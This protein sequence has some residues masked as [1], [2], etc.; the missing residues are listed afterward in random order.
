[1]SY[2]IDDEYLFSG[3]TL[4]SVAIGRLDLPTSDTLDMVKSL[5]L[6][7]D[8]PFNYMYTG[9]GRNSTKQEQIDNIEH[10]LNYLKL[11]NTVGE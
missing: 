7:K 8:L 6:I 11:N 5:N 9:H 2:L 3:D 4:F 10:W 1:M